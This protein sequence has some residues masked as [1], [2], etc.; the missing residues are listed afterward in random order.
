MVDKIQTMFVFNRNPLFFSDSNLFVMASFRVGEISLW[1]GLY[2]AG[3]LRCII[4]FL[5]YS[6]LSLT[7]MVEPL[8][9][10]FIIMCASVDF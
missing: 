4:A 8:L 9:A 2:T 7:I 10:L 5:M 6:S 1:R 3:S